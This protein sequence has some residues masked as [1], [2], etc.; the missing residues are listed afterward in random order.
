MDVITSSLIAGNKIMTCA[1]SA[2]LK[3][4]MGQTISKWIV[5]H[6][7]VAHDAL[8]VYMNMYEAS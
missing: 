7:F 2:S 6:R 8:R 4:A 1:A 5:P 3:W